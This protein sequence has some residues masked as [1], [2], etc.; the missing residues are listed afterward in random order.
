MSEDGGNAWTT[1]RLTWNTG[2]SSHPA[3]AIDPAGNI[4][5][6][7]EDDVKG[8]TEIYYKTH[9]GI[10]IWSASE[11]LTWSSQDCHAPFI[12]AFKTCKPMFVWY[13]D[14]SGNNEI[15]H[16]LSNNGGST[17]SSD[18]LTWNPGASFFPVMAMD[19]TTESIHVF[20]SDDTPGNSEIY[21]RKGK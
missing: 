2:W 6:V 16:K 21:Y 11:R 20:W 17:W 13:G 9:D 4:N 18:R 3:I 8:N 15:Y 1:E 12:I 19:Y 5:L 10:T 14:S 7:W